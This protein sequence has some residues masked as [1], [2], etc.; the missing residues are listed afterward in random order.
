MLSEY[1]NQAGEHVVTTVQSILDRLLPG[2]EPL[3]MTFACMW[4]LRR[5]INAI[6]IIFGVF[7][8]GILGYWAGI[9]AP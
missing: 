3:L 6:W 5:K 9:L 1:D 4:L 7:A 8:I 2:L